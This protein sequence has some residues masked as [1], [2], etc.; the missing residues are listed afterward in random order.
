MKVFLEIQPNS[1]ITRTHIA[2]YLVS[3]EKCRDPAQ[4]F[5][6]YLGAGKVCLC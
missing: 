4:A 2:Q 5:K 3:S 1:N 6:R